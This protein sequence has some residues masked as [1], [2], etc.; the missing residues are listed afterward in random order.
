M[1][2]TNADLRQFILQFFSDEEL[3]TLCFDYFR[4]VRQDFTTGMIRNSKV[5]ILID[6]CEKRGR[7]DD[8]YAALMRERPVAWR[9]RFSA[10]SVET[11]RRNVSAPPSD[12][13]VHEKTG[14]EFIRIPAGRFQYGVNKT[15]TETLTYWI[16][17]YPVTNVQYKCFL[18]ANPAQP[19]PSDDW[20]VPYNW[21]K[22][23][24]YCPVDKADHPVVLVSWNDAWAFCEWAGLRL[25]AEQ[26]WEKAARG[27]D[28]RIYPWGDEWIDGRCNT[29]ETRI[30][31]TTRVGQ[32]SPQS[33]S[34]FGC[35]DMAGNVWEW[36][37]SWHTRKQTDRVLR[38][39]SWNSYQKAVRVSLRY[40]YPPDLASNHIGFRVVALAD[41]GT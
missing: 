31:G 17:R 40:N 27:V 28:G 18:D 32:Y 7:L 11:F 1:T 8:L 15:P 37:A 21:D 36:T 22:Q 33:D 3:E 38:G 10:P 6:H 41:S 23:M 9:E 26:E 16:G 39:G 14:I 25:P 4:E 19:V 34:P 2:P 5:M 12:R 13:R 20:A 24:R 35:A 30:G 29:I